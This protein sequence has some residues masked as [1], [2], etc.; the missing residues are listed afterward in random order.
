MNNVSTMHTIAT[1]IVKPSG[2]Q[3]PMAPNPTNPATSSTPPSSPV[4]IWNDFESDSR[5]PRLVT[6]AP[7]AFF[8]SE[9][10]LE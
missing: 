9:T 3:L 8:H 5:S 7:A 2:I 10:L 4:A 6:S 1:G